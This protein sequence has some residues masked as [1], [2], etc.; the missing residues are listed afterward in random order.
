MNQPEHIARK[1]NELIHKIESQRGRDKSVQDDDQWIIDRGNEINDWF[2]EV[3][4][5]ERAR[6]N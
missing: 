5:N 2:L 3:F 4:G 6:R 1:L